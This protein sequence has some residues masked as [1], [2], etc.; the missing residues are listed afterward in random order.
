M[1]QQVTN[2]N[3]IFEILNDKK[4][5][6]LSSKCKIKSLQKII[7]KYNIKF[8]V[9]I[10]NY[11]IKQLLDYLLDYNTNPLICENPECNET[12]EYV[13]WPNT[14]FKTGYKKYCST[15]CLHRHRSIKQTGK[16]NT[17]HKIT[18]EQRLDMNYRQS[19]CVKNKILNGEFTPNITN[20]WAGS[21]VQ[22]LINNSIQKYR[23][24]WE[25]F[26]HLC[27]NELEYE[28]LRI[29]YIYDDN[30]H[31]YITDFVDHKNKVIYEI[32]PHSNKEK[33][34]NL[35]KFE[36]AI[37]W[38]KENDYIFEI[39]SNDW[40]IENYNKMKHLLDNQ[41]DKLIIEKRLKQFEK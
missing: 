9:D 20:S 17:C 19:Q 29:K 12:C 3:K 2:K 36:Y 15:K 27:N 22:L 39:I 6:F 26:F 25:A 18:K 34:K 31:N 32:K 10:T 11:T 30:W 1:N 7:I 16:N 35:A 5:H 38:C 24:S 37:K 23:S 41:E 4:M 14:K 28:Q 21:R 13:R 33:P 40:F 8:E